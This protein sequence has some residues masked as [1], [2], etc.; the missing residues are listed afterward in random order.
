[1]KEKSNILI[2]TAGSLG[3]SLSRVPAMR[4]IRS[5]HPDKLVYVLTNSPSKNNVPSGKGVYILLKLVNEVF[6]YKVDLIFFKKWFFLRKIL[7]D[8]SIGIVYNLMPER[9]VYQRTRDKLFFYTAGVRKI[10]GLNAYTKEGQPEWQ[11]LLAINNLNQEVRLEDF[12]LDIPLSKIEQAYRKFGLN[13]EYKLVVSVG[14]TKSWAQWDQEKWVQ[15]LSRLYLSTGVKIVFIG[16]AGDWSSTELIIK[17]SNIDA[18]N[19]CGKTTISESYSILSKVNRFLGYDSGPM[20]LAVSSK[21]RI[22]SIFSDHA[23]VGKWYPFGQ[24]D[25]VIRVAD[26]Q[27][28]NSIELERVWSKLLQI[29]A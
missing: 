29:M 2:F 28:V 22:I 3:D 25:N 26:G 15:L 21:C 9:T 17:K 5:L 8:R 6:E 7:K 20:H 19:L 14:T 16:S 18:K 1:M 23:V 13:E 10:V 27:N 11:R 4:S 12:R 24:E